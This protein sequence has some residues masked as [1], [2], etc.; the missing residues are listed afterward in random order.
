MEFIFT[1]RSCDTPPV[2]I[3]GYGTQNVVGG[4]ETA[5]RGDNKMPNS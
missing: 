4:D 1:F 2:I 5:L 3:D